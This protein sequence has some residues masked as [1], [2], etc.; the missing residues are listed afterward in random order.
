M[1][2]APHPSETNSY[3]YR[4]GVFG[5]CSANCSG[6]MQYRSVECVLQ[7]PVNPRVV[8]ES[9]CIAQR[10]QRPQSQQTCNMH[11]CTAEYSVSSYSVVSTRVQKKINVMFSPRFLKLLTESSLYI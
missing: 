9:Y 11:H 10:L 3:V 1:P 5:E 6:G 7:D 2:V 4:T 8:E